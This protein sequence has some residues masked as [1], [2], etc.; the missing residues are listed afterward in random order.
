MNDIF[1]RKADHLDLAA[2]GDVAFR[3]TTL[4]ECVEFVH[5]AIPELHFDHIDIGCKLLGKRLRAPFVIAAMT[6]GTERARAINL[7]LAEVAEDLGIGFG[8]GSQRAMSEDDNATASFQVRSAAPTALVLG[9]IGG[10]QATRMQP[11]DIAALVDRIEADALCVHL[12]PAMELIQA[13]GDRDFRGILKQIER[14]VHELPR[15]VVVK[16]TGCG[17]SS[18]VAR[19]LADVGVQHVDVSG[20][21]GTSWVAVEA[22]RAEGTQRSIGDTFREWGV[23]TAVSIAM[24]HSVGFESIVATG[25][26]A[27]GLDAA[28]AIALGAHAVGIARPVLLAFEHGGAA[29]AREYL[30]RVQAE[31]RVAML[32]TGSKDLAELRAAPRTMQPPLAERL[33]GVRV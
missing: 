11:S 14:L 30:Q 20:A 15:P 17:L 9:N 28:R 8:L 32:L 27:N 26:L 1:G 23:P 25:G 13:D 3:K 12:N 6:G 29:G 16:E 18:S 22:A 2:T 31:L 4:L 24:C 33:R 10:V 19:R 7:A 21:G 5:D